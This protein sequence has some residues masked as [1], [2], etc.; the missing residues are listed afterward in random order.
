MNIKLNGKRNQEPVITTEFDG[1]KEDKK[2]RTANSKVFVLGNGNYRKVIYGKNV[3]YYNEEEECYRAID[4]TPIPILNDEEDQI[5]GYENRYNSLKARFSMK[6]GDE[7]LLVVSKGN[8]KISWQII[9]FDT[10]EQCAFQTENAR[11]IGRVNAH[12]V[13]KVVEQP[14]KIYE[15]QKELRIENSDGEVLYENAFDGA[16][17]QYILGGNAVKENIIVKE[18]KESYV[19]SFRV[20]AENLTVGLSENKQ[21]IVFYSKDGNGAEVFRIPKPVMHD[22]VSEESD[23]LYYEVETLEGEKDVYLFRIVAESTWVN[24]AERVFPVTIDPIIQTGDYSNGI[25]YDWIDD[26]NLYS[27]GME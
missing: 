23:E 14:K 9:D 16:D 6:A 11:T 12:S 21:K 1:L 3:H 18:P 20:K 27:L 25:E 10:A 5:I 13:A 19:Y 4:N 2:Q 15:R 24:A 7:E 22:S 17:L 8:H 26:Q